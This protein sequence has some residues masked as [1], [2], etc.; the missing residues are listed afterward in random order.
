MARPP[1]QMIGRVFGRLT[2]TRKDADVGPAQGRH[3]RYMTRCECGVVKSVSGNNLRTGSVA[4]CGCL[5]VE[6]STTHGL[7]HTSEYGVW[8]SMKRRCSSPL[9]AS[10]PWYGGRGIRV[11][12]RWLSFENFYADM[13]PRPSPAH[14]I[15]R[16]DN[17]K[18][19]GPGNCRWALPIQQARNQRAKKGAFVSGVHFDKS[20]GKFKACISQ[21][22]GTRKSLGTFDNL[23]D[24]VAARRSAENRYWS[25]TSNFS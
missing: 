10:Y 19:Y 7:R 1:I 18:D 22:K 20:I 24:A 13:G 5:S 16:V 3:V 2:V 15:D 23:F 8:S 9:D 21:A 17:A 6:K 25:D 4:S 14:S 11:C 12:D